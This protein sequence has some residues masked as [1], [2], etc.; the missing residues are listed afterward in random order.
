VKKVNIMRGK[1]TKGL[2]FG[3]SKRRGKENP[4]SGH[5]GENAKKLLPPKEGTEEN[6]SKSYSGNQKL[7]G[8]FRMSGGGGERR[9]R[10]GGQ[11]E[12]FTLIL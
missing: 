3:R 2:F 7:P 11:V 5:G 10:E 12:T 9:Q 6:V 4:D 8:F 1:G